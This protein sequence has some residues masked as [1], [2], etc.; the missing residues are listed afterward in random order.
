MVLSALQVPFFSVVIPTYNRADLVRET[1]K[2]VFQQA[3][4]D[5]EVIVVD[6]GSTEDMSC[7]IADYAERVT[8]LRQENAGPPVARNLAIARAKGTY[9]AFHA[10]DDIWIAWTLHGSQE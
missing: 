10:S 2:S 6:D 9:I 3:F 8:F 4:L 5:F 7:V 1:L